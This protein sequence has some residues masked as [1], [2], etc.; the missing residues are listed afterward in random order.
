VKLTL[1]ANGAHIVNP[2]TQVQ[3]LFN[4]GT[5]EHYFKWI[6]GISSILLGKSVTENFRVALTALRGTDKYLWQREWDTASPQIYTSAGIDT[7]VEVD[8]ACNKRC[9]RRI[10]SNTLYG[11]SLIP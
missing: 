6:E 3:P 7:E 2:T 1:D 4:Q 8:Q 10:Y 9:S 5:L 11:T